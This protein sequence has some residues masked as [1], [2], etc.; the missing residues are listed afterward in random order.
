MWFDVGLISR[1]AEE[2]MS[3]G[4]KIVAPSDFKAL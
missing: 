1:L 2:L 4:G 3:I